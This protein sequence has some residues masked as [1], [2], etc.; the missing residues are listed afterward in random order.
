MLDENM[1]IQTDLKNINIKANT[2]KKVLSNLP[3]ISVGLVKIC[4]AAIIFLTKIIFLYK[5]N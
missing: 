2:V 1:I 5:N 3:I 4:S